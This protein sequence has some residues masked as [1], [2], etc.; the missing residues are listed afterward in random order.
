MAGPW[1]MPPA[2]DPWWIHHWREV[3]AKLREWAVQNR[4]HF[5]GYADGVANIQLRN[6]VEFERKANALEAKLK[7]AGKGA[8]NGNPDSHG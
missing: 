6:A 8:G 2:D 1:C 4:A 7:A 5:N 3:A